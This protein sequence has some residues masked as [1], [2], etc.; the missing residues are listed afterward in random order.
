MKYL[1]F[2]LSF[3][4]VLLLGYHGLKV[5]S[6]RDSIA[7]LRDVNE[8]QVDLL[9]VSCVEIDDLEAYLNER[10][11][12]YRVRGLRDRDPWPIDLNKQDVKRVVISERVYKYAKDSESYFY[13]DDGGCVLW[14]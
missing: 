10:G 14:P 6:L 3:V 4:L 12:S 2:A 8:V 5:F 13:L 1:C 11:L 7:Y 9:R